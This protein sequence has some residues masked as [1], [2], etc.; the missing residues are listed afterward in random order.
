MSQSCKDCGCSVTG[1]AM[2]CALM[3]M[4]VPAT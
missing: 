2:A 1:A 3:R 4:E